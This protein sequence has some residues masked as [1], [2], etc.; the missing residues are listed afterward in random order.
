[1]VAE[2]QDAITFRQSVVKVLKDRKITTRFK[3]PNH[4]KVL[5]ILRKGPMTISDIL[6]HF[7]NMGE[8]K[9]DKSIYRYLNNLIKSKLVA[10]AGK[11]IY[12]KN[13]QI[14]NTDT[15]YIRTA[16]IFIY[17]D[18]FTIVQEEINSNNPVF[19]NIFKLL[20]DYYGKKTGDIN[21]FQEL[22][23]KIIANKNQIIIDFFDNAPE[24][25][26]ANIADLNWIDLRKFLDYI[27]WMAACAKFDINEEINN[28]LSD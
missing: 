17:D 11:R 8:E 3:D 26:F 19:A 2:Y 1:M 22:S 20:A 7:E 5:K 6:S 27:S 23:K 4:Y 15:L 10:K 25:L 12:T 24:D 18:E 14:I 16:K 21:C 28:C 9:S 13:E